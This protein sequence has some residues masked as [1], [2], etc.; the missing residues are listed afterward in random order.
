MNKFKITYRNNATGAVNSVICKYS[1]LEVAQVEEAKSMAMFRR[2]N[3]NLEL[4]N[5][6]AI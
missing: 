6:E 4:V 5:V 2:V 1:S 3:Q